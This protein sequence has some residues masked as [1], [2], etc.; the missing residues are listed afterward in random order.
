VSEAGRAVV[1]TGAVGALGRA[2]AR[3][4]AGDPGTALVLGDIDEEGLA[5]AVGEAEEAGATSTR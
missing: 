1:L 2:I 3:R 5:E 4:L